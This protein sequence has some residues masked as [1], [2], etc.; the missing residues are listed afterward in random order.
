MN[1][2]KENID[3]L[4]AIVRVQI[5]EED[6]LPKVSEVLQD[7][8][9]KA[10][11]DGFRP[12]KAPLGIIKKMYGKAALV[13]EVNKL[14]SE[15]LSNYL[16]EGDFRILG[17]PLPN[18][19]SPAIDWDSQKDFDFAFDIALAPAVEIS[20]SKKDKIKWYNI[21]VSDSMI[22]D[23]SE[24]YTKRFGGFEPAEVSEID[25][26]VKGDFNELDEN[27]EKKENGLEALDALVSINTLPDTEV[28]DQFIG[29]KV[30]DELIVD[31]VKAFPNEIDR[32]SLLKVDKEKLAVLN[33]T[34]KYTIGE[35][36]RFTPVT[37]DQELFDKIYGENVVTSEEEFR[38]RIKNE[39][40]AHLDRESNYKFHL[41]VKDKMVSKTDLQLPDDFLKRWMLASSKDNKLNPETLEKEYPLFSEDLKWQLIKD[42]I[43]KDNEMT[44]NEDEVKAEAVNVA[45]AQFQQYGIYDAPE[46]QL[47][48]FAQ[49]IL[50]NEDEQRRI[51]ERIL[52]DK[53]ISFV[54]EAVKLD[55]QSISLDEFKKLFE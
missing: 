19:S 51:N 34:F 26:M 15:K 17:E 18:E 2:T 39:L 38:E 40:Q 45:R 48:Q 49:S 4:N 16:F 3:D 32:A 30:G 46:E 11:L 14:L 47:V 24:N 8:R 13:D 43:A 54:R 53:V 5:I 22:N 41:D 44:V 36:S 28:K 55:E 52:E 7:F 23:Q 20:L 12:G 27:G 21:E 33:S 42:K 25:D 10:K 29:L 50:T 35:V 6:Y 37:L 1:I 9:R 31:I